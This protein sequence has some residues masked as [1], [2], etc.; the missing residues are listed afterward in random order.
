MVFVKGM[1]SALEVLPYLNVECY[2]SAVIK[3]NP[4]ICSYDLY[5]I[6]SFLTVHYLYISELRVR[7]F[8]SSI[9]LSCALFVV[10]DTKIF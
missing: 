2:I 7:Y 1:I 5:M 8:N 10:F 4:N 6:S 3:K 9:L